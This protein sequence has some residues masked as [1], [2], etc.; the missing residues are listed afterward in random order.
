MKRLLYAIAL[1]VAAGVSC[2]A[3]APR[4]VLMV[5]NSLSYT[6][7]LP[8]L[9]AAVARASGESEIDVQ[10]VATGG[11]T[12]AER[13]RDGYVQRLLR[14]EDWDVLVLQERGGRIAC[15]ADPRAASGDSCRELREAHDRFVR[16]ARSL[17]VKVLLLGTWSPE[18]RW[19]S[20]LSE[21]LREL[22]VTARARAVDPGPA[23]A[24]L[25]ARRPPGAVYADA[26]FHPTLEASVLVA[27]ALY[28]EIYGREPRRA[29]LAARISVLPASTYLYPLRTI[30]QQSTPLPEPQEI[31]LSA[32][33]LGELIDTMAPR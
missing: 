14:D 10:L 20:R 28:R 4:R 5:G 19:Q 32:E 27:C 15:V 31:A 25:A 2:A 3:D 16:L 23:L 7:N 24:A 18:P 8:Q 30:E 29:G 9:V 33:R 1:L 22:A 26:Q 12:I 11:G 17:G 21:G 6:N 13:W